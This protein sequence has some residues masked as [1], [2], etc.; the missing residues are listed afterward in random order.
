M[1]DQNFCYSNS[2]D[3]FESHGIQLI[4]E[5]ENN[6]SNIGILGNINDDYPS[7]FIDLSQYFRS[8]KNN[9]D[10]LENLLKSFSNKKDKINEVLFTKMLDKVSKLYV[11]FSEIR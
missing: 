5:K 9:I 11:N 4:S 10:I 3:L 1:L 8:N 7:S 6:F 2:F